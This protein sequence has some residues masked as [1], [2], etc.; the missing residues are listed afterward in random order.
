MQTT[1]ALVSV[2]IPCYNQGAFVMDALASVAAQT[3]VHWEAIVVND[4]STDAA[5][6]ALL[7]ELQFPQTRVLHTS[8][9]GLAQARNNGIAEAKG[10][11]ILPLDADDTIA[12]TY[13][14]KAVAQFEKHPTTILVYSKA[15]FFGTETGEWLLPDFS[16][17]TM[18][19]QNV[20]FCSA[21]FRKYDFEKVGGYATYMR[22]GWEDWDLWLRMLT[23]GGLVYRIP[24]VL[25]YYRKHAVSM[26]G[27]IAADTAKRAFLEQQLVMHH[28]ALYQQYYPEPITML[29]RYHQL[30]QEK[31][32]FENVKQ[33]IYSSMSYQLGAALLWP[34]KQLQRLFNK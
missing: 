22:Y 15:A 31:L 28:A 24:E 13:I 9:M 18:L 34:F 29:R 17:Q 14:E 8:N 26:V 4:G 6:V 1:T 12:S 27:D 2:I 21:M 16:M 11:Y 19:Q 20:I 23:N 25:F 32:Q 7:A 30:Q 10:T 3:Y 5:T 33:Q